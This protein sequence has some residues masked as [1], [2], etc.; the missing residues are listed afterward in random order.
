MGNAALCGVF[1]EFKYL[2]R[3]AVALSYLDEAVVGNKG[4]GHALQLHLGL[5]KLPGLS[6]PN[7]SLDLLIRNYLI[8]QGFPVLGPLFDHYPNCIHLFEGGVLIPHRKFHPDPKNR[9][10]L[11]ECK[12]HH[13]LP[14]SPTKIP[15]G[16]LLS[17]GVA[18]SQHNCVIV[19]DGLD[20]DLEIGS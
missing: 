3:L 15:H 16:Y 9:Y 19:S 6:E 4:F 10:L 14:P 8:S 17:R 2:P 11:P 12:I 18:I 20:C 7:E 5:A 13:T 1:N